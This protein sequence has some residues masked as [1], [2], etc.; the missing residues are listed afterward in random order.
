[1]SKETSR[2]KK[3][4]KKRRKVLRGQKKV[5]NDQTKRKGTSYK[6]VSKYKKVGVLPIR[7]VWS[8]VSSI[9]PF[10][11]EKQKINKEPSQFI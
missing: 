8:N 2:A 9:W 1:M 3:G 7:I 5:T 11:R 4:Q 6:E 10:V